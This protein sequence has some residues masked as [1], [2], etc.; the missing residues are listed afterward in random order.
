MQG[1]VVIYSGSMCGECGSGG[2]GLGVDVCRRVEGVSDVETI[3]V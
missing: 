1:G 2:V 3:P